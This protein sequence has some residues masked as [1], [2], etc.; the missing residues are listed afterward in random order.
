MTDPPT[1]K[2]SAEY[3]PLGMLGKGTYGTCYKVRNLLDARV[4][5]MKCIPLNGLTSKELNDSRKE[6]VLLKRLQHA[7]IVKYQDAWVEDNN[8]YIIMEYCSGG[9]LASVK[10]EGRGQVAEG[11]LWRYILH[12]ASGLEFLHSHRILHRCV[13]S[14]PVRGC[15]RLV[16]FGCTT[17]PTPLRVSRAM[18]PPPASAMTSIHTVWRHEES[19]CPFWLLCTHFLATGSAHSCQTTCVS[20]SACGP[21]HAPSPK[22][23]APCRDVKPSNMFVTGDRVV[24]GDLGLGRY[25]SPLSLAKSQVGTPIYFS[26]ELCQAQPYGAKS[27]VWAFGCA[28]SPVAFVPQP[29]QCV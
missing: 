15:T 20:N 22:N 17:V 3:E 8:L 10:A 2:K 26:P 19:C 9:D 5:V 1:A 21:G 18:D 23:A 6:A 7:H 29:Q 14:C 25:V 11:L 12:I 13:P 16:P 4:S 28:P 27:D 24:V